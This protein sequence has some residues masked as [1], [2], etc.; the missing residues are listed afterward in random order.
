MKVIEAILIEKNRVLKWKYTHSIPSKTL[1]NVLH[2]CSKKHVQ[3]YSIIYNN[4][5]L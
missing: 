1:Q 4:K 2:M 5:A 3:E